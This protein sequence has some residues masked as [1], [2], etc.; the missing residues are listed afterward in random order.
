[1]TWN[2][3]ALGHGKGEV[4]GAGALC[5]RE[6]WK[7][8]LRPNARKLQNSSNVVAFLKMEYNKYH[9]GYATARRHVNKHFWDVKEG[10][11]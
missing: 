11:V 1:M 6:I 10:E 4:D 2:Y 3:F 9:P 8:Q 7:E 5:K